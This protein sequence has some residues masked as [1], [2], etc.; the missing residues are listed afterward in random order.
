MKKHS[1]LKTEIRK[2]REIHALWKTTLQQDANFNGLHSRL[3]QYIT[4][5]DLEK[6]NANVCRHCTVDKGENCCGVSIE[7]Y[8]EWPLLLINLM[9]GITIPDQP[10]DPESCFF[11][12]KNGCQLKVRERTCV[13]F[14]C[15][16]FNPSYP[17]TTRTQIATTELLCHYLT[18][19]IEEK[20]NGSN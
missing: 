20:E 14:F 4:A 6:A 1:R 2:A 3:E 16:L 7:V 13:Q 12:E 11:L 5:I 9:L 19:L 10:Y 8:Y 15:T 18:T 17:E